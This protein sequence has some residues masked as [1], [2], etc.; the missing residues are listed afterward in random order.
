MVAAAT[1]IV[2]AGGYLSIVFFSISL[3]EETLMLTS[4]VNRMGSLAICQVC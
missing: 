2:W 1:I 3:G 4:S